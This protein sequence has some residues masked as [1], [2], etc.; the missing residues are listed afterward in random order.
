MKL[1]DKV[2]II[3]GGGGGLGRVFSL[4][5]A[6]EGAKVVIAEIDWENA[7]AVKDEVQKKGG[8]VM[9]LRTDVSLEK[10]TLEMAQKTTERFGRIDIL[11]NNAAIFPMKPW[12]QITGEEWDQVLATNLKGCFLCAKAVFP[13][14]K[15]QGGGKI[16]NISS[17]VYLMGFP[18]FIHYVSSK[19]GIIGFT[20][21]LARE[22]GDYGVNVNAVTLGLTQ[23]EAVK[24]LMPEEVADQLASN[25]CLKRKEMPE[26]LAGT[27][28]FLASEDSN[29]ITGQ[30]I[31][32][33]GGWAMH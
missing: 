31:N 32:V 5:V 3:T 29:F 23:T 13:H 27:V 15:K 14:M 6:Q 28:L 4:A 9:A 33:D 10:D 16:I 7:Q 1:K 18:N 25:Q 2:A 17:G 19:A 8:E 24:R 22:V 12:D 30:I 21:A 20:R 26:D 11:V